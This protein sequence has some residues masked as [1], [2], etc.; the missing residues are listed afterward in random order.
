MRRHGQQLP[1][2]INEEILRRNTSGVLA[3]SGDEDHPYA[4][5]MSYVYHGGCIYFHCALVGHKLDAIKKEPRVSF[6][7]IDRD[8]VSYENFITY[9]QSVIAFG[10]AQVIEDEGEKLRTFRMLTKRYSKGDEEREE[11]KIKDTFVRVTMVCMKIEHMTG[12][13]KQ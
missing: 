1:D 5:P 10:T 6:C 11:Q 13:A 2:G 7:V 12:K 8:D 4:V 3:V 9:Y